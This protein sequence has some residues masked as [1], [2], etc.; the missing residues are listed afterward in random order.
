VAG[1][2]SI[3][4]YNH[5][6]EGYEC[7]FCDLVRQAEANGLEPTVLR[8]D[9]IT[10]LISL[11]RCPDHPGHALVIPNEHH[12]NI[13]DLPLDLATRIHECARAVALAMK[14]VCSCDGVSVV[15]NNEP[16]GQDVWHYHVHVYPRYQG[17]NL[18]A[19]RRETTTIEERAA[20]AGQL[21]AGLGDWT[22]SA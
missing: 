17:D 3:E 4:M 16:P 18:Y 15:Q 13:Y 11:H 2:E 10:A 22:P 5:A 21:S 19:G 8:D 20:F 9:V 12:E 6:P 14:K 7:P 1:G